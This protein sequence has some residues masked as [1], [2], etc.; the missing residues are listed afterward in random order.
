MK[1]VEGVSAITRL[2]AREIPKARSGTTVSVTKVTADSYRLTVSGVSL[3]S[4][5]VSGEKITIK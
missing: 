3:S 5:S 1:F 2:G 4:M